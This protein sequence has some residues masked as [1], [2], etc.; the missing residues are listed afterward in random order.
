VAN[1]DGNKGKGKESGKA[2]KKGAG[3]ISRF[4][5]C[6]ALTVLLAYILCGLALS[7]E[8]VR[9]AVC[10]RIGQRVGVKVTAESSQLGLPFA[11]VLL[12]VKTEDY[13]EGA[14]GLMLQRLRISTSFGGRWHVS[15]ERG[16]VRLACG[17]DGTWGPSGLAELGP[18]AESDLSQVSKFTAEF[19][20]STT[21]E[22]S[23]LTVRWVHADGEVAA[24]GGVSF[25]VRPAELAD[26]PVLYHAFSALSVVGG[27]GTRASGVRREW[28]AGAGMVY[29]EVIREG[30]EAKGKG[31]FWEGTRQ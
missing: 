14:A 21:L 8:S 2:P 22:V 23:D 7:L 30:G 17:R 28:L 10:D 9:R 24:A 13:E 12:N 27:D 20:S 29:S 26:R 25:V 5:A 4:I 31:V 11:I 15:C 1:P 18:V 16:S 19:C 3:F 6:V